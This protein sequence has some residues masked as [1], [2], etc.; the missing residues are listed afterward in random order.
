METGR[1]GESKTTAQDLSSLRRNLFVFCFPRQTIEIKMPPPRTA[2]RMDEMYHLKELYQRRQSMSSRSGTGLR[3]DSKPRAA[4]DLPR[5]PGHIP[6]PDSCG[7]CLPICKR[8]LMET[9]LESSI[10]CEVERNTRS[11]SH[12]PVP[13][14]EQ[15]LS[16][17]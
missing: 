15:G 12:C 3:S 17:W 7:L 5:A 13:S 2:V 10:C 9:V 8:G 1:S 6:R 11:K 16:K 4:C 14:K